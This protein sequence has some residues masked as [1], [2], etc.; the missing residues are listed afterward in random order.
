MSGAYD[1]TIGP[2][3]INSWSTNFASN[4]SGEL[5]DGW[6][7]ASPLAGGSWHYDLDYSDEFFD[8]GLGNLAYSFA[9]ST[10][11]PG[12]AG[13]AGTLVQTSGLA[14]GEVFPVGTTTNTFVFT[15]GFGNT[16][17]CSF[18]VT[19]TDDEDP[20]IT[21]PEDAVI[22]TSNEGSTGDC[23]GQYSWT[24][25][26]PT[27]NCEID[28]YSV[29]YENP[30][31]TIDGPYDLMQILTGSLGTEA[32]W[33]FEVGTSIVTYTVDDE[34]GNS[35]ECSWTVSVTDD[36]APFFVTCPPANVTFDVFTNDCTTDIF[37]PIP[38][39]EDNCE[40]TVTQT[41]GVPY[42]SEQGPGTYI[43]E[44]TATD[45]AGL[46]DICTFTI[47]VIDTENP[48][49]INCP[50]DNLIIYVDDNCDAL[51]PDYTTTIQVD[52]NCGPMTM[53]QLPAPG[54]VYT[55]AD[56][57]T[58]TVTATDQDGN[59]SSCTFDVD[60]V[61]DIDPV[62]TCPGDIVMTA[63]DGVCGAVVTYTVTG[64]DNCNSAGTLI[65][66]TFIGSWDGSSSAPFAGTYVSTI[67]FDN[68]GLDPANQVFT[69]V[70]L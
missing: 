24:H 58:V 68:G 42:G 63:D 17:M 70:N 56:V 50:Y 61:D 25:P 14:S 6:F 26:T 28:Y 5:Y 62:V 40:V 4:A 64:T 46:T 20:E 54:T 65:S 19:I 12:V 15:D 38:V 29:V 22:T 1:V 21:C 33:N 9:S 55:A 23:A 16:D 47:E 11:L 13:S 45:A 34:N 48:V 67:V 60:V 51:L 69:Q 32:S 2:G 10:S 49:I 18:E 27:D 52:E 39:A 37:W 8:D 53:S 41:G 35:F 36:E 30:D 57:V 3:E 43:I 31:G 59:S 7:D 66:Y 44:Y